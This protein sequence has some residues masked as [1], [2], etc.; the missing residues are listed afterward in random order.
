MTISIGLI[1]WPENKA[2]SVRLYLN[3]LIE[4]ADLL[5]INF[6][7]ENNPIVITKDYL[8]GLVNDKDRELALSYWW[9]SIDDKNI[10]NSKDRSLLMS[11]LAICFLSMNEERCE[12][13]S[14]HLSWFIEVLGFLNFDLAEVIRFMGEYFEFKPSA[15]GN[16]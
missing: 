11:R 3:F 7:G 12:N 8:N 5:N 9:G 13:I 10:R 15:D 1:K 14:E 4:V 16:K 6:D 2:L